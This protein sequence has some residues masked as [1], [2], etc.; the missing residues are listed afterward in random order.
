[1]KWVVLTVLAAC[2]TTSTGLSLSDADN[3]P[4]A[5]AQALRRAHA[6]AGPAQPVAVLVGS[7]QLVAVDLASGAKRW[8]VA[9][10]VRSRLALGAT[11]LAAREGDAIVARGLADGAVRWTVPL[12]AATRV[13]GVAAD[14][15]VVI[16]AAEAAGVR[17]TAALDAGK[18]RWRLPAPGAIGAP[19]AAG[20][21]VYLPL[22][23]QWLA[24][25]DETDGRV[26]TRVRR[27]DQAL[28]GVR[29]L[30][31]GVAYGS[32]GALRL[33]AGPAAAPLA[34]KL[35]EGTETRWFLDGYDPVQATYSA[36]DRARLLWRPSARGGFLGPV[37]SL[38]FRS[39]FAFDA[40]SGA[41]RWARAFPADVVAAEHTGAAIAYAT[42]DGAIGV[43]DAESGAQIG[44][45]AV[46][47]R[48][49]GGAFAAD[50]FKS[51]AAQPA[52]STDE[53]LAGIARDRESRF[54][55]QKRLAVRELG[56]R[57]TPAAAAALVSLL[58]DPSTPEELA[59]DAATALLARPD[60]SVVAP[61]IA[62]LAVHA[63]RVTGK[64]PRGVGLIAR[65]LGAAHAREAV[66]PLLDHL[67]DPATSP[68]TAEEI[69]AA[70]VKIGDPSALPRL[71]TVLL[72]HRCD[73]D[74]ESVAEGTLDALAALGG[75][76]EHEVIAFV[77]D[78][79]RTAPALAA[80]AREK[81]SH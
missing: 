51:A 5:L 38:S 27:N 65:A 16:Y 6:A 42:A 21:L 25:L 10:D 9:A 75:A 67:E 34:A 79:P 45:A 43:L 40:E 8:T 80:H 33:D 7:G 31:D 32:R 2:A 49:A 57:A 64:R 3:D 50:G 4:A 72:L 22:M 81:L 77:A 41:L 74:A 47:A 70:L 63:D 12:A 76:P 52:P 23:S 55:A 13:I 1:V 68:A 37:V 69:A 60:P 35:P 44:R 73:P 30:P 66:G 36:F 24:V 54:A 78:D 14:G 20:G 26:L 46:G 28:S 71:Q 19:A 56:R 61:L 39:L 11:L 58:T 59:E 48:I 15:D 18:E 17:F 29:A 53:T 62:A